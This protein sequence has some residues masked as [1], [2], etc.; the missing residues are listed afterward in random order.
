MSDAAKSKIV[1]AKEF[2][3][4]T[5][6][7]A[8][9]GIG[10]SALEGGGDIV[11]AVSNTIQ[12]SRKQKFFYA[13]RDEFQSFVDK[14]KIDPQYLQEEEGQMCLQELMEYLD[15]ESPN[16]RKFTTLKDIFLKAASADPKE[17][18]NPRPRQYMTVCKKLSSD[19]IALLSIA[20]KYYKK[21]KVPGPTAAKEISSAEQWPRFL[22]QESAGALS[23]GLVEHFEE[24]LVAHRLIGD[25]EHSDRSGIRNSR[26]FR[27]TSLGLELCEFLEDKM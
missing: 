18:H 26:E 2:A 4:D 27:L 12:R 5:A 21:M 14:G 16:Q 17:W 6:L 3:L 25:R 10:K 11:Q 7:P 8:L 24:S 1:R 19:E 20:Y 13:L 15:K 23:P 9:T 22:A